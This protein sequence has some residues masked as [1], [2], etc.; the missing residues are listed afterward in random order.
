MRPLSYAVVITVTLAVVS[1]CR[2]SQQQQTGRALFRSTKVA[3]STSCDATVAPPG[4]M[5][6]SNFD[7]PQS[8]STIHGWPNGHR[9]RL[10]AYCLFAGLNYPWMPSTPTWQTW[11]TTTQAFLYQYNQWPSPPPANALGG[12][13]AQHSVPINVARSRAVGA[14]GKIVNPAPTYYVNAA[15]AN[16]PIYQSAGCLQAQTDKNGKLLGYTLRDGQVFQS[17]GDIMV[18][19]VSYSPFALQ[20]ILG[21]NL[22]NGAILDQQLP[23]TK[24]TTANN[25]KPMG[26]YSVVLKVMLWPVSGTSPTALPYWNWNSNPPGSSSD[27]QYAGYE[28]QNF[29]TNA[30]A[31]TNGP[32]PSSVTYLYGVL[33][34]SGTTQLGPNTYQNPQAVPLNRFY[35]KTYSDADLGALSP[36]DQ[37]LLDASAFWAYNRGFRGGDSLVMIAMHIMT[38]EQSDWTFQS[39][40]WHPD[41]LSCTSN[42]RFCQDR[43]ASVPGGDTTYKNYNMSTTYGQQEQ[44]TNP[45]YYAPPDT[46]QPATVWPVAYNPYIELAASHPITTNCMNC[47]HRAAWPPNSELFPDKKDGG[48]VSAYLQTSSPNPNVLEVFTSSDPAFNGLLTV[49]SMW[50]VSD[51]AGYPTNT[52]P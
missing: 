30:V 13:V 7:Y 18:A 22:Y 33:D 29:W 5:F 4:M 20:D 3:A 51:R 41:A 49:D 42:T 23:L 17:N 27:G 28:M 43:P 50:A 2:T 11:K 12:V 40:W 37:A 47:H 35:G 8:E 46:K 38:K 32:A 44:S 1:S 36:C 31:I 15:V 25:M 10:H 21:R 16:N 48:R 9:Q 19:A 14:T 45:N 26:Q 52:K 24:T 34:S 6:P 39:A